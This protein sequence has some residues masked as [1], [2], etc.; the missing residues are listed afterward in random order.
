MVG[1]YLPVHPPDGPEWGEQGWLAGLSTQSTCRRGHRLPRAPRL[2]PPP[3][4]IWTAPLCA[5]GVTHADR[6]EDALCWCVQACVH[7]LHPARAHSSVSVRVCARC[8]CNLPLCASVSRGCASRVL[9]CWGG[10]GVVCGGGVCS[11]GAQS[12]WC[13]AQCGAGVCVYEALCVCVCVLV[14]HAV[15]CVC[16]AVCVYT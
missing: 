1:L 15:G 3:P 12:V 11:C 4:Q 7:S 13:T 2:H 14:V 9:W 8:V 5:L 10:H 16:V 6:R